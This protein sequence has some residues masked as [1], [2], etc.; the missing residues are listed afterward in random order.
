[1]AFVCLEGGVHLQQ[2][3]SA[4]TQGSSAVSAILNSG[5]HSESAL[6][7]GSFFIKKPNSWSKSSPSP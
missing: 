1:M 5:R 2:N 7:H 3:V 6:C 4:S